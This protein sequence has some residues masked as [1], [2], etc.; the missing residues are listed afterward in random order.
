ME[1]V[2]EEL[3]EKKKHKNI[4]CEKKSI[5]NEKKNKY[6]NKI[7]YVGKPQVESDTW[8]GWESDTPRGGISTEKTVLDSY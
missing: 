8:V 7:A 2:W 6:K 4:L 1:R 5:F 3:H